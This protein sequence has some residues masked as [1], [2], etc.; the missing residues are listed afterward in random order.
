MIELLLRVRRSGAL[1][2]ALVAALATAGCVSGPMA[3]APKATAN[4]QDAPVGAGVDVPPGSNEDWIVNVGRR[5]YF[6]EGSAT[7]DDTAKVT[8]DHQAEWLARYPRWKVKVQGFSD[9]PGSEAANMA[10]SMKRAE[11]VRD[12][13]VAQG[14]APQRTRV[15][16]Y[17]RTA[18][19]LVRDCPDI[20]CKS[21]NRRVITNL[22]GDED[23]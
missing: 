15:K 14:V 22:E 11:A 20:S 21:Q 23:I 18:E 12:Y 3:G 7:L 9:D 2:F 19:R 6:K 4:V 8:L 10:L 1:A 13:L 5:T 17:G 16:G